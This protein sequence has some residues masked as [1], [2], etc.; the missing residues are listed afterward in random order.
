MKY[1]FDYLSWLRDLSWFSSVQ[2]VCLLT[3]ALTQRKHLRAVFTNKLVVLTFSDVR[4]QRR[5]VYRNLATHYSMVAN[6]FSKF[7]SARKIWPLLDLLATFR[8]LLACS[9]SQNYR[10]CSHARIPLKLLKFA[11][12]LAIS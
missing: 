12:L 2:S 11:Q 1:Y 10:S 4:L 6:G 5:A 8:R 7:C 9:C 3:G